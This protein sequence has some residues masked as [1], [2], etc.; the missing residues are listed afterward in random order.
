M[1]CTFKMRFPDKVLLKPHLLDN[2]TWQCCGL[3]LELLHSTT[4][5]R[6]N[7]HD[8]LQHSLLK[9]SLKNNVCATTSFPRPPDDLDLNHHG[10]SPV[11]SG[12]TS[13][14]IG[15]GSVASRQIQ[16]VSIGNSKPQ[17]PRYQCPMQDPADQKNGTNATLEQRT[18]APHVIPDLVVPKEWAWQQS[19]CYRFWHGHQQYSQRVTAQNL[20]FTLDSWVSRSAVLPLNTYIFLT[21]VNMIGVRWFI[22]AYFLYCPNHQGY[23]CMEFKL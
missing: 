1:A 13:K 3:Q 20:W 12:E 11:D 8:L 15:S 5:A 2:H 19:T 7:L 6:K 14:S 4:H 21:L 18:L 22:A 17:T 10:A 9:T 23:F 16:E